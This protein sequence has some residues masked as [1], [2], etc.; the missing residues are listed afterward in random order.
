MVGME[1][2]RSQKGV[3]FPGRQ[4]PTDVLTGR[5]SENMGFNPNFST[6]WVNVRI[7]HLIGLICTKGGV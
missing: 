2:E 4:K 6:K 3:G 7:S 5:L 1:E